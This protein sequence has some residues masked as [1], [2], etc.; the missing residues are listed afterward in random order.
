[1][2]AQASR[3]SNGF[4]R[5]DRM[6]R[7]IEQAEAEADVL[8]ELY[9]STELRL[10]REAEA[11]ERSRHVEAALHAIKERIRASEQPHA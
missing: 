6:Q 4:A 1:M 8:G 3:K 5:F 9:E 10:E 11:H 7:Q 2:T